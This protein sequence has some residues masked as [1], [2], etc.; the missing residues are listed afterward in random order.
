MRKM[1]RHP[2]TDEYLAT[3]ARLKKRYTR[4][5]LLTISKGGRPSRYSRYEDL[6]WK[7]YMR[8]NPGRRRNARKPTIYEIKRMTAETSPYYFNRKTMKHWGQTMRDFKV[9]DTGRPGEYIITAPIRDRY[10]GR[11]MGKSARL[12]I[13]TGKHYGVLKSV[14]GMEP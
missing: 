2:R 8:A 5:N 12:F 6:A 4:D 1:R 10:T 3:T 11:V 13:R 14:R 9:I 7:K